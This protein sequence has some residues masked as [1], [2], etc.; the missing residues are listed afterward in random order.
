MADYGVLLEKLLKRR[1]DEARRESIVSDSYEHRGYSDCLK[2][3]LESMTEIDHSY[4]YK[5]YSITRKIQDRLD[6]AFQKSPLN[7]DFRYEGPIQTETH[8]T[9]FG[10]VTL[11]VIVRPQSDKPWQEVQMVIKGAVPVLKE[12]ET[13][14]EVTY[15][16]QQLIIVTQ[17]PSCRVVVQPA[18]WLNNKSFLDSHREIDRGVCEFNFGDK[19]KRNHL[20]FMNIARINNKDERT[21]GGL[22]R[23]IRLLRTL[24]RDAEPMIQLTDY[25]IASIVYDI[26]EK[27]L[28]YNP[29]KALSLLTVGSAQLTRLCSDQKY[30]ET[31]QSPSQRE[32]IFGKKPKKEEVKR[33]KNTLDQLIKDIQTELGKESKDIYSEIIY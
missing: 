27:Q 33:L 8:I 16:K 10:D 22:K 19:T 21:N 24:Q 11:L 20:P 7:I 1:Y 17:K 14:K 18:V 30:F 28:K 9:L 2:Y 12:L 3:T 31:L 29:K 4:S 13:V 6:N 5:I 32:V 25:E 23:I 26:P 15:N